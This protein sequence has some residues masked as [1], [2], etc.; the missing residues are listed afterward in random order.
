MNVRH[1]ALLVSVAIAA[2]GSREPAQTA[3]AAS[4]RPVATAVATPAPAATPAADRWLGR[5][6][7][8]EGT[9]LD[10]ATAP[11]GSYALEIAN[12]DGPRSFAAHAAGDHLAFERD[13]RSLTLTFTDGPGTGM[14]WL[15][16]KTDCVVVVVGE[17]YCR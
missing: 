6:N 15:Q 10:I 13:G 8:P 7:G 14:K 9:Y 2:C 11:D 5:W 12:L 3:P 17:G 16:D 4:A 1:A